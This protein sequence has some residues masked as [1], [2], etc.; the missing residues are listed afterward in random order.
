MKKLMM[1]AM[2]VL[3]LLI[4]G[5]AM[6]WMAK[7]GPFA[8][9]DHAEKVIQPE[10]LAPTTPD[11]RFVTLDKLIVMLQPSESGRARYLVLDLVFQTDSSREKQVKSQLP[12]L[13]SA[14]YRALSDYTAEDIRGMEVDKLAGVLQEAYDKAYGARASVPFSSVQIARQMLE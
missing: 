5:T 14:S 6:A 11:S 12:L 2:F 7:F 13:R 10:Q 8:R 9:N 3:A 1:P 4:G